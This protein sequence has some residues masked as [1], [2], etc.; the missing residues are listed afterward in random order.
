MENCKTPVSSGVARGA[1]LGC[2]VQAESPGYLQ[3]ATS[4]SRLRESHIISQ[5]WFLWVHQAVIA[6]NCSYTSRRDPGECISPA[7]ILTRAE[8]WLFCPGSVLQVHVLFWPRLL[9]SLSRLH[10]STFEKGKYVHSW[11]LWVTSAFTSTR[12]SDPWHWDCHHSSECSTARPESAAVM[13]SFCHWIQC[14]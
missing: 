1:Y 9:F 2:L 14:W 4:A 3:E 6:V 11:L 12:T 13:S 10:N 5:L 7:Q 8:L